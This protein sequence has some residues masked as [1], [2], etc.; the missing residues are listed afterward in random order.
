MPTTTDSRL[1]PYQL[2]T[3]SWHR[4]LLAAN[5]SPATITNYLTGLRLFSDYMLAQGMPT[6]PESITREHVEAWLGQLR[7]DGAAAN[8]LAT[9]YKALRAWFGWMLEEGELPTSPMGRMHPP[10]VP[11]QPPA[12]LT[13]DQLRR[14][15]KQ[16]EGRDFYSRRD[17]AILRLLIDTGMRRG[18]LAGLRVDDIDWE[19]DVALVLGKGRRQ[20]A[21]PFGRKTAVALD[22]YIRERGRHRLADL[23]ALWLGLSGPLTGIGVYQV[24][25]NRA[26]AAGLDHAWPHLMRHIW[27][28]SWLAAGGQETDLM[29]L[30]GWR[31]RAMLG[32]YGAS[33]ADARARD[34]HRR[35]GLGDQL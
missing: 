17:L 19:L 31:S 6:A 3:R 34:A 9:R 7:A 1:A 27:A 21:C 29:R 20:R 35:L 8:T 12:I 33:A 24:V 16:C 11:E 2:L 30:A 14:V 32:R 25:R 13:E 23:P 28:H 26:V 4:A 15:L 18:E 5:K 10:A 22:R